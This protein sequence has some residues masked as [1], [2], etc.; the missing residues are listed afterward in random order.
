MSAGIRRIGIW[1]TAFLGDAVL[2]L[3]LI[4]VVAAAFP[5][6]AIDFHV[7]RGIGALFAAQPRITGIYEY[8]KRGSERGIRAVFQYGRKLADRHYDLWISAHSSPR[9]A[10]LALLSKAEVRIGYNTGLISRICYTS[11]VS[12]R[13]AELDEIERLLELLRPILPKDF[14][15]TGAFNDFCI[16]YRPWQGGEPPLP[17]PWP[18]L[19]LPESSRQRALDFRNR[20]PGPLLGIHP[21]SIWGTKRWP[22]AAFA[23]ICRR[24]LHRGA[25]V[26]LFAGPDEKDLAA[27][28]ARRSGLEE[29]G[30]LHVFPGTLSLP[31]LAALIACLDCYL[32]NDSGLTHVAWMSRT[33]LTAIFGPTVRE[34]GFFPRGSTSSVFEIQVD[35]RPCGLHGHQ[36]CP[37]GH[38]DCMRRISPDA[39]WAD[40]RRKLFD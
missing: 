3:P 22:P 39:V 2:T 14:S 31:D 13:F 9:S 28:V 37:R 27:E 18:E 17:A 20:N 36:S 4:Q 7:R 35:C 6:A 26:L 38:H 5:G 30:Q 21:G 33:P 15:F 32:A 24:A 29:H 8:D 34:L 11:A 25:H 1:N 12:R 19:V 16:P 23:E 10:L 40:V